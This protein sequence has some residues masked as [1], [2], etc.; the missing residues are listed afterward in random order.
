MVPCDSCGETTRS[1]TQKPADLQPAGFLFYRRA[2]AH[3]ITTRRVEFCDTDAAGIIH[4]ANYYRYMEQAEH[5][6]FR[7]L[8]LKIHERAADGVVYGWPRVAA[9]ANFSAPAYYDDLLE[10]RLTIVRRGHRSLTTRY[11][12]WRGETHLATG[13]MKTAYCRVPDHGRLEALDIPPEVAA[14][15]DRLMNALPPAASSNADR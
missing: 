7:E 2:M 11:E 15:L 6:L 13:E 5:E 1:G 8:G 10:V 4:F 3:F 12:F 9:S 14:P